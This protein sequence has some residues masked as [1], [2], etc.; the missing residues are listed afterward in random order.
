MI[1]VKR[2]K[3]IL[4]GAVGMTL[5]VLA[6]CT[7][8][9]PPA[10]VPPPRIVI[11]PR[12]YP[13][14]S[15]SPN[16]IIP[17]VGVDGVR[18]TVNTGL[19]TSQTTWNLRSAYNVA[20]LNCLRPEHAPILEGYKAFLKTHAKKLTQVNKDLDTQFR[21][22]HGSTYIRQRE[23]YNTQVYNY[24][25]L[26]PTLPAF[27]DAVLAMSVQGAPVASAQLDA[28]A[29]TSLAGL[30]GVFQ[31]FYNSY[32]QYR[33]DLAAWNARYGGGPAVPAASTVQP[34]G[35]AVQPMAASGQPASTATR[36]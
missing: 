12:P 31:A 28:F 8:P 23:A 32:D 19:S 14:M 26:P 33:T 24:F 5:A 25:A 4:N 10:P 13:P 18:R 27:C 22:S 36:P 7:K 3:W 30:E 20:A 6:G 35:A 15:A 34:A 17:Q 29:M 9:P 16:L 2:A 11:P 21:A 1:R